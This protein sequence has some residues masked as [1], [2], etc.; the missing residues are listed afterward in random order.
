VPGVGPYG[1]KQVAFIDDITKLLCL[2][3]IHVYANIN[4]SHHRGWISLKMKNDNM[5]CAGRIRF[6][7]TVNV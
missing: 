4:M 7:V 6:K 2:T 3:V 5:L 1:P